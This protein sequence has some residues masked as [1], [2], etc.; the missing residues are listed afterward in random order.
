[1]AAI[2]YLDVDDEITSAAARIRAQD[3]ERIALVLPLGSRLATSRINF[4]LLAREAENHGRRLEIV[5]GDASARALAASAGLQT[6]LSVASFEGRPSVPASSPAD[7]APGSGP[8]KARPSESPTVLMPAVRPPVPSPALPE[9]GRRSTPPGIRPRALGLLL[10]VV[11]LLA[12][13]G[14][15]GFVLLPSAQV[16]LVTASDA[17]GPLKLSVT[18]Q[19]GITR[20]DPVNLLAP[21]TTYSFD[22]QS[23]RTF[24]ATGLKVDETPA[25]GEVTF[26]SL[27]TGSSNTIPAGS[28]VKTESGIEF[29]TL[30]PVD[31]PAAQIGIVNNQFVVI[32][33]TKRVGVEAVLPGESGNVD[34]GTIVVVPAGE[35]PRR[36]IVKNDL[37]TTG[38][39]HT[40]SPQV[41]QADV[42]AALAALNVDL[43]D[44]FAAKV[45]SPPGIPPGTTLFT[46]TATLGPTT[47]SV[48]PATLVGTAAADFQLGASA[49]GTVI[50]VDP[51]PVSEL[52]DARLRTAVGEGFTLVEASIRIDV[53]TPIVAGSSITFP[54]TVT[55]TE[56]RAVDEAALRAKM[57]GLGIPQARS[58][59]ERYGD[60]TITVW[61]DWVSTIPTN[62]GRVT[63][64]VQ[65][66][67][68]GSAA[69]PPPSGS[70]VP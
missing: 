63:F 56:L 64:T 60:V 54:V 70:A 4:R 5:T 8:G 61:P 23:A 3:E 48:D 43:V 66:P 17:I 67:P 25:V 44:A 33:S 29:R 45:A 24:P 28:I 18:A 58:L 55:A 38:G 9:V 47:P 42:D 13:L 62:D 69:S 22:V 53:G 37:P 35:N 57:R 32:P 16:T 40:E 46:E 31:L 68:G 10:L 12:G 11:A 30:D 59:L 49:S 26:S 19:P 6:H 39:A 27:N 2:I 20:P 41:A 1:M 15:A 50:G 36:T 34:A 21:A 14:V 51:A 52:A 7:R 65:G